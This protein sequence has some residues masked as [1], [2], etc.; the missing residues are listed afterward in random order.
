MAK[1]QVT[2]TN[3]TPPQNHLVP[4]PSR[5]KYVG[6]SDQLILEDGMQRVVLSWPH[7]QETPTPQELVTGV[8]LAVLGRERKKGEF[9][10]KDV[11]YPDIQSL[12]AWPKPEGG[13]ATEDKY[14]YNNTRSSSDHYISG[15]CYWCQG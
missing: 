8:V 13:G 10:V 14:V 15:M 1:N 12:G 2:L 7:P 5:V 9:E 4:Q 11:C 6:A 3:F